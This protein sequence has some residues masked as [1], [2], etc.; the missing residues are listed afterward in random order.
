MVVA[1]LCGR[2]I[3]HLYYARKDYYE[4]YLTYDFWTGHYGL[5]QSMPQI[6][7]S[8]CGDLNLSNPMVDSN[9]VFLNLMMHTSVIHLHQAAA[10][11]AEKTQLA[12]DV[13]A[14]S[15]DRCKIAASDI[16]SLV[17]VASHLNLLS[18]VRTISHADLCYSPSGNRII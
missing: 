1:A 7:A 17:R 16:I 4:G 18:T 6:F 12:A 9:T 13:I 14:E 3:T 8:I 15:E 11:Q 2:C 5:D 10:I